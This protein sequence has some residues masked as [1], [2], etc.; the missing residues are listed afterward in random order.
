MSEIFNS[1]QIP[2]QSTPT[3]N[4]TKTVAAAPVQQNPITVKDVI[5]ASKTEEREDTVEIKH[6]QKEKLGPIT[7]LKRG[8]AN[9][10]KFFAT[11]GAYANGIAKGAIYGTG[12]GIAVLG[13]GELVNGIKKFAAKHKKPQVDMEKLKLVPSKPLAIAAGAVVLI[14]SIWK[15]SLNAT[16]ARS[17]IHDRYV[18][19]NRK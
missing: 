7:T 5:A 18:G 13:T 16:D 11:V 12:A 1:I 10:K 9:V 4:A 14:G 6:K 3:L 15:A 17:D 8:I 2:F 19:T